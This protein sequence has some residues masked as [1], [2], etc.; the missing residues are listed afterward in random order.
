VG[1][2]E[3]RG[4]RQDIMLGANSSFSWLARIYSYTLSSTKLW[5]LARIAILEIAG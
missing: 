1:N 3:K 5:L 4:R 2:F